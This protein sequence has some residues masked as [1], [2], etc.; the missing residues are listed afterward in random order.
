MSKSIFSSSICD[1][2]TNRLFLTD[3]NE[4][5]LL[6]NRFSLDKNVIE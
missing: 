1:V 5:T 3:M 2:L 6:S 4:E